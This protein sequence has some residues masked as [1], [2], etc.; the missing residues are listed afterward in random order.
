MGESR[1]KLSAVLIILALAIGEETGALRLDSL[2][3]T[4]A[5]VVTAPL[6]AKEAGMPLSTY[7]RPEY[8]RKAL[9]E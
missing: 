9:A 6:A 5:L 1:K 8:L 2:M 7:T 4:M 3:R